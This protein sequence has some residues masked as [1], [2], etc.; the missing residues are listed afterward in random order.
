[1][2][3][4]LAALAVITRL[5]PTGT[6]HYVSPVNGNEGTLR[7]IVGH[8]NW[9]AA[10]ADAGATECPGN[11]FYPLLAGIRGDVGRLV[12]ATPNAVRWPAVS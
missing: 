2:T 7:T 8:R 6:T 12:R 5:N 11:T 1:L 4:V 9:H 10:N 3:K